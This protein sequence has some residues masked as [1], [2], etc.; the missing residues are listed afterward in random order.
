MHA[1]TRSLS[2]VDRR[3]CEIINI[4]QR[5]ANLRQ[6]FYLR[7]CHTACTLYEANEREVSSGTKFLL[8]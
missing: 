6:D 8:G 2:S 5:E 3:L 1:L 7:Q 4:M